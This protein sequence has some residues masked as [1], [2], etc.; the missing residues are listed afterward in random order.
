LDMLLKHGIVP[1]QEKGVITQQRLAIQED[2]AVVKALGVRLKELKA[3]FDRYCDGKNRRQFRWP[4]SALKLFEM[5]PPPA[6]PSNRGR[7]AKQ[8]D[9]VPED[10]FWAPL[11]PSE[12]WPSFVHSMMTVIDED[13]DSGK[14]QHLLLPEFYE[15]IARV[16]LRYFALLTNQDSLD[17]AAQ[18]QIEEGDDELT[19]KKSPKIKKESRDVPH[20][21]QVKVFLE[22]LFARQKELILL[23]TPVDS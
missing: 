5:E 23:S 10:L 9:L 3:I 8:P 18:H 2:P 16:A 15:W 12:I 20:H 6:P 21:E 7:K 17:E 1:C 14:Y 11:T 13:A 4:A 19:K 22:K